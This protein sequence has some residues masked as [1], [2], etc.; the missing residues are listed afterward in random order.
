MGGGWK[1]QGSERRVWEWKQGLLKED[2]FISFSVYPR[3]A[4]KS[5]LDHCLCSCME[6]RK[7][8]R[9]TVWTLT[10]HNTVVSRDHQ[11]QHCRQDS[12]KCETWHTVLGVI[13]LR[14]LCCWWVWSN[15]MIL[16]MTIQ[17]EFL[18]EHLAFTGSSVDIDRLTPNM[19]YSPSV[20]LK[21]DDCRHIFTYDMNRWN[22]PINTLTD[23]Y[24][25]I[26]GNQ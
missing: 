19:S 10:F 14:F 16:W 7:N 3:R 20:C 1:Q 9:Q 12:H 6:M 13:R 8:E 23:L 15:H 18:P 2:N 17:T 24:I 22:Y 11:R 26:Y 21:S 25:R 5:D 4:S